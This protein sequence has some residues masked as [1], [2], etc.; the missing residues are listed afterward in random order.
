MTKFDIFDQSD[1]NKL[2]Q[3]KISI[4]KPHNLVVSCCVLLITVTDMTTST[5]R[6]T[7]RIEMRGNLP[8]GHLIRNANS[9]DPCDK[10][11]MFSNVTEAGSS[12]TIPFQV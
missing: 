3:L 7:K 1:I 12:C 11:A 9:P 8:T 2:G 5:L 10:V 4:V 6:G